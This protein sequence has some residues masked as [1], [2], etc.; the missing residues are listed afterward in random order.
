MNMKSKMALLAG[1]AAVVL[2]APVSAEAKNSRHHG[3]GGAVQTYRLPRA[4]AG[5]IYLL[6]DRGESANTNAAVNFQDTFRIDY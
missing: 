3:G 2:V 4:P 5:R 6:E 1:F